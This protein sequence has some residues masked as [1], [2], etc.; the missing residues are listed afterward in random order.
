MNGML[1]HLDSKMLILNY[2]IEWMRSM[3]QSK[4]NCLIYIDDVL[5]FST[6]IDEHK[7]HLKIFQELTFE[8]DLALSE[9]K[10]KIGMGDVNFLGLK[11]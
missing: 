10:M 1:C 8:H 3:H 9:T 11:I 2:N 4:K 7:H 6:A 5:I